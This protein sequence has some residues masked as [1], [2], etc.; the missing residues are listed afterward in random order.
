MTIHF[1]SFTEIL[2]ALLMVQILLFLE[3]MS[4][5]SKDGCVQNKTIKTHF[6]LFLYILFSSLP[7]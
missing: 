7:S 3:E 4:S 5:K 1:Y 6:F 2:T